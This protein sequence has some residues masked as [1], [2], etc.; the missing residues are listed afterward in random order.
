MKQ[1]LFLVGMACSAATTMHGQ[2]VSAPVL[3]KSIQ[4]PGV[5]G[6]FDHLSIDHSG[7]RLFAAATTNQSV[8]V[9]DLASGKTID[10]LKGFGKPHGLLWLPDVGRLF[11]A[12]GVKAEVAVFEGTPLKRIKSIPLSEDADDMA[13]DEASHLLYVGHGG[14]AAA[15]AQ[16]AVIDVRTIALVANLPVASHPEALEYDSVSGNV[17]VNLADVGKIA[18]IDGALHTLTAT[19]TLAQAKG[20]TPLAIDAEDSVLLVGCR[21]PATLVSLNARLSNQLTTVP[22]SAGSDDLFYDAKAHQAYLIAGS[23]AFQTFAVTHGGALSLLSTTPTAPGA[24]TGLLDATQSLL[25]V[26]IPSAQGPASIN[27]YH[28]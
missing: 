18:V 2:S 3:V 12:D 13:Y 10:S 9:I 23:G 11:V 6:K 4:L 25:Y 8:E 28:L 27:V 24:K 14:S 26:A 22:A 7:N 19:W 5:S 21:T 20:N 16:V 15:P 17:F 1:F